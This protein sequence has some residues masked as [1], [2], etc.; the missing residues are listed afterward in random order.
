MYAH[1]KTQDQEK[2]PHF[3][4][5]GDDGRTTL[6]DFGAVAKDDFRLA[7]Y[8]D[9]EEANSAIG[10]ALALAGGTTA[11]VVAVLASVQHDLFDLASDL[12]VPAGRRGAGSAHVT[13]SHIDRLERAIEHY[14]AELRRAEGFVLPGGTGASSLIFLAR[15]VVRRAERTVWSAVQKYGDDVNPLTARYLNRLSALLFVMARAR[16]SEHGDTTW[17][18]MASVTPPQDQPLESADA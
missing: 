12:M 13:Q 2:V 18:P 11:D 4:R 6:G 10:A 16:N 1:P 5:A 14:S 3:T 9:C 7:A 8:G 15:S 17:L